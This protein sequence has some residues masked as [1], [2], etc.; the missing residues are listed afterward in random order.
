MPRELGGERTFT[1]DQQRRCRIGQRP[2]EKVL[3]GLAGAPFLA[4]QRQAAG[5]KMRVDRLGRRQAE[6]G[7]DL[8]RVQRRQHHHR[9][10]LVERPPVVVQTFHHGQI[11][12]DEHQQNRPVREQCVPRRLQ[13]PFQRR[14]GFDQPGQLVNDHD[15]RGVGGQR[16]GELAEQRR[17]GRQ[18]R[19][20]GEQV[21]ARKLRFAHGGGERDPL[22][23]R[24]STLAR[25]EEHRR[26]TRPLAEH[27]D[28]PGLADPA[29]APQQ[30]RHPGK[31]TPSVP[32]PPQ[33]SVQPGKLSCPPDEP[34]RSHPH[35]SQ[36]NYNRV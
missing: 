5:D 10:A 6:H 31:V 12:A 8:G 4:D 13:R 26:H 21:P 3:D 35:S 1:R 11:R 28:Q 20:G 22:G 14:V 16:R 24:I 36:P 17:P 18:H 9:A 2:G 19:A 15:A 27:L 32:H 7:T 33:Q 29:P 23:R 34:A 30:H 25:L